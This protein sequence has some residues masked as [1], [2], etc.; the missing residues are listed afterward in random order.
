MAQNKAQRR[1]QFER[2]SAEPSDDGF[3]DR[4]KRLFSVGPFAW[5]TH[6]LPQ[7]I[8]FRSGAHKHGLDR[9]DI[10][11]RGPDRRPSESERR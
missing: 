9:H 7:P 11:E 10:G 8:R 3:F 1:R 5:V 2:P 6:S 4:L